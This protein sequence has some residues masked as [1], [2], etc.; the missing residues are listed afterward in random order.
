MNK[1]GKFIV[2][3]GGEGAGKTTLI[4]EA[5]KV[6]GDRILYSRETGGTPFAEEVRMLTHKEGYKDLSPESFFGLVWA[7]R[8]DHV[9]T[10]IE[11]A[12]AR[13]VSV[14][15]D[16][17]DSST[18]AYQLYGQNGQHLEALFWQTRELFLGPTKPDPYIFLDVEPRIALSRLFERTEQKT[19]FDK[20]ESGFHER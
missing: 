9:R 3:D 20:R 8:A 12:L 4:E 6:F 11:P 17:F 7:A 2:V 14:I 13:G 15:S 1:R 18:F 10:F 5:K 16:R 19:H